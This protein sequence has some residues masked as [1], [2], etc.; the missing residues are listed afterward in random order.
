M[1]IDKK[2]I[3]REKELLFLNK[4]YKNNNADLFILYGRRRI[5]KTQLSLEFLKNKI[6][7]YYMCSEEGDIINI[8][9]FQ[10]ELSAIAGN[11][12]NN[13]KIDSW[14]DLFSIFFKFYTKPEKIIIVIDEFPY[15]IKKN[16][17]IPSIFQKLWDEQLINK[18]ILLIL[19]G[20]S[21]SIME[22][23]VLNI[24]S[25]LYGRR[26]AQWN[27]EPI[28][29][30]HISSFLP[31][32]NLIDLCKLYFV[33]GGIPAYLQKL[34]QDCSFET[35]IIEQI[36]TKGNFLNQEGNLLLNYEFTETTNYK[37]ILSAISQGN[38]KQKEIVDFTHLDYSLVSKYLFVLKNLS[39]I[40][41]EIPITESKSFKGRLYKIK[42]NYLQFWFRYL[43]S[44]SSYIESH[45]PNE[46]YNFYKNDLDNYFGYKFEDLIK[47]LFIGYQLPTKNKYNLFGR[48]WGKMPLKYIT[49]KNKSTYEIDIVGVDSITKQN[50]L[51]CEVKWQDKV[52]AKVV[53]NELILK[54]KYVKWGLKDRC[55]EFII[56]AKSFSSKIDQINDIK[57][58]CLDLKDISTFLK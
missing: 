25:P 30:K 49:D 27:L 55:E 32:H 37:L 44:D 28:P 17:S 48:V 41:E 26:T 14:Y 43:F 54:S 23:K 47:E 1:T 31:K 2:F 12:F 20:S 13:L 21:I 45:E 36:F 35:N 52:N 33:F 42:D 39:I 22:K 29:F 51:F 9:S 6:G 5:G 50:I 24:K 58:T 34:N 15:L 38:Q 4:L 19:T 46:I 10:K 3:N 57:I 56:I 11:G 16:S 40:I 18:N 53:A 8:K 7:T